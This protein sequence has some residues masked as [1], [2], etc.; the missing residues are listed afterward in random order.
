MAER[1]REV[2]ERLE[3]RGGQRAREEMRTRYGIVAPKAYGVSMGTIQQL[4][5]ALGH[6]HAL[7]A[8]L[9]ATGW[10]EARLLA[11]YVDQPERVTAAQMDRWAKDFDNWGVCDT[12]CFCLFDR[13]PHAWR[14]VEQWSRRRDEFVRRAAFALLA[15]LALHDKRTGDAAFLRT[16][17][18]VE[19][20]AADERNFVKKGVSWAL[21][22]V[23]QRS[24]GLHA[25]SMA[26]ATRLAGSDSAAARWVGKDTLRDLSRP[27]VARRFEARDARRARASR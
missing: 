9:W 21:R 15:S 6:D 19:R 12:L 4:A 14:K 1:V 2:L 10:Y 17:P 24:A 22:G 18:L 5:K 16:L 20:A 13:T 11:A 26:L 7:A 25:A 8:A 3:R 23:G 27:L